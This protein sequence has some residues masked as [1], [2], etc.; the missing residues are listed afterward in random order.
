MGGTVN[1]FLPQYLASCASP[2]QSTHYEVA[3]N[4]ETAA[5]GLD[6]MKAVRI[7]LLCKYGGLVPSLDDTPR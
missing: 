6:E 5:T 4:G 3:A 7:L 1:T 2:T